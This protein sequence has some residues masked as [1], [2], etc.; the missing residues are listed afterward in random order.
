MANVELFTDGVWRVKLI[1][2][3]DDGPDFDR[4]SFEVC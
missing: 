2:V 4:V 3:L 1:N